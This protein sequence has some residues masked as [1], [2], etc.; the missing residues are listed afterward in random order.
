MRTMMGATINE[1]LRT[2]GIDA[3]DARA[4]L[5][6]ALDVNDAHFGAHPEQHLTDEQRGRFLDWVRRRRAGEPVAYITGEREFWSLSFKVAPGV[7][8]PRPETELLVELALERLGAAASASVLDLGT[9]S[10]CIAVAIARER[11]RARVTATDVSRAAL[12]IAREN[13]QRHGAAVEFVASDWLDALAS[14]HFDLILANPPYVAAGDLHLDRGDLRF[15][16]PAA[17][18]GGADGLDSIRAIISQSRAHLAPGG[19]LCFEHGHEQAERCRALLR[20]AGYREVFSRG[21]L[22]GIE[23]ACGGCV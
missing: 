22:A 1:A 6:A 21:D 10:G 20:D 4:L 2:T 5:R 16:P 13:A 11:P 23:R 12:A 14:R 8:I 17:L 19:W 9:G 3:A 7:L 15:E 18:V